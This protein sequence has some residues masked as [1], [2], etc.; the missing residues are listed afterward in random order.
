MGAFFGS[1]C[2]T[3]YDFVKDGDFDIIGEPTDFLGVNFYSHSIKRYSAVGYLLVGNCY[4]DL[5]KTDMGW[6][7]SPHA[8][9]DLIF[10]LREDYT[11]I[12]IY[13][14]ENGC[15][16]PDKVE[17]GKVHDAQRTDYL[18]KHL[19]VI[20]DVNKNG[21]NV[22]GYYYWS[23]MDNFEWAKGYS[24]RFG[25]VYVDYETQERIPKDSFYYYKDYI[26]QAKKST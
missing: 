7:V 17:N 23:F 22:A 1:R 3:D 10:R 24:K 25:I 4:T 6:D 26:K 8:L 13:I 20:E 16:Y 9:R 21:M 14:T 19:A 12:P 15:A 5:P 18:Q 11:D 2:A